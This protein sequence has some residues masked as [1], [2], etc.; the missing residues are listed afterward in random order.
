M[1]NEDEAIAGL[2]E[3]LLPGGDGFP[4]ASAISLAP[5][6]AVRLRAADAALPTRLRDALA[7]Q[8][9]PPE[10]DWV[11]ATRRLEATEPKSFD[12]LR[13]YAYLTYYEQPAVVDAIR[14]LGFH[15]NHAPLPEGYPEEPFDPA[16][17][18]PT[19]RRGRWIATADVTR[20]DVESLGLE[21][22]R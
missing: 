7:A 13:K 16:T 1:M 15:Y 2:A 4:A 10:S 20:V 22:V 9:A 3:T 19:H 14:A 21:R 5:L 8:P 18:A 12:A 17:D 11:E 6:L